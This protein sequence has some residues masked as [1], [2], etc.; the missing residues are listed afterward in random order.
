M[1]SKMVIIL[2]EGTGDLN[3]EKLETIMKV[4]TC[5]ELF[6]SKRATSM[7]ELG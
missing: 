3:D 2:V 6:L 4:N 1:I 7:T 5:E